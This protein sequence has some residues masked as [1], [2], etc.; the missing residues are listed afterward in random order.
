MQACIH[1][2]CIYRIA[3][4]EREGGGGGGGGGGSGD[5]RVR[6]SARGK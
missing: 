6:F 1:D 4:Q 5:G 2:G 3:R